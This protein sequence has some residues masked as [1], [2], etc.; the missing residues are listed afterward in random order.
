MSY[1]NLSEMRA[2][3]LVGTALGGELTLVYSPD[4]FEIYVF[5]RAGK[6]IAVVTED[7]WN[8]WPDRRRTRWL[9]DV[10]IASKKVNENTQ[11]VVDYLA[12][13]GRRWAAA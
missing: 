2:G 9:S 11:G 6:R 10:L 7:H 12:E 5:N 3:N 13:I 4:T 1:L 8:V